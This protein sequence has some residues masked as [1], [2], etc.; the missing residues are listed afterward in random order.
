ME[1]SHLPSPAHSTDL[2]SMLLLGDRGPWG[3]RNDMGGGVCI[4]KEECV[5]IANLL[6]IQ[7]N[8]HSCELDLGWEERM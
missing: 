6:W 7:P 2:Q 5:E 4:R 3:V 1:L 8:A